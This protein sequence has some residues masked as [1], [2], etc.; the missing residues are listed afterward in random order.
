MAAIPG[1]NVAA[2][3]VPFDDQDVFATHNDKYGRGG[4]R[5]CDTLAD[6][7]A[8]PDLRRKEGM[9]VKVQQTGRVYE[10]SGG[11]LNTHWIEINFNPPPVTGTEITLEAGE[12]IPA[13][14]PLYVSNSKLYRASHASH[15]NVVGVAKS[16]FAQA[17][18][19]TA[20][21]SGPVSLSGLMVGVPYFVGVGIITPTAPSSGYVVRV[22]MTVSDSVLLVNVEEPIY[23]S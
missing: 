13:G 17:F 11:I 14:S 21:T 23:L 10:L 5:V 22:G 12:A 20:V 6:R 3:V 4:F 8:I 18:P 1:T 19:C 9:W 15:P 16:S 2:M 7:D